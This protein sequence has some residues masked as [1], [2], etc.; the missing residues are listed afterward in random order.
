[1]VLQ[2]Y[3]Y[4]DGDYPKASLCS[5]EA[6]SAIRPGARGPVGV[7]TDT[8]CPT[9]LHTFA[10]EVE[11]F[12]ARTLSRRPVGVASE[13]D[14]IDVHGLERR[15]EAEVAAAVAAAV[16]WQALKF[17]AGLGWITGPPQ[18]GGRGLPAE[19][20]RLYA[21]RESAFH[22][23]DVTPLNVGTKMLSAAILGH[24]SER[25][26]QE[27]TPALHRGDLIGCQLFSE[28]D[29]GS[30]L[31]AVRASATRHEGTWR[32][33]GEKVWTS[34]AQ[35][36]DLG[37]CIARTAPAE[38]PHAGLTMFLVDMHAPGVDV[39]PLRQMNGH[40]SFN[41]VLLDDVHV[42]DG[43]RLG[44]VGE[45]WAVVRTT[46]MSERAGVGKGAMDLAANAL[47]R[48]LELAPHAGLGGDALVRQGLAD[49][50]GRVRIAD[51]V[52]QQSLA[53][54]GP[55]GSINKLFRSR[56]LQRASTLAGT[57]LGPRLAAGT[58]GDAMWT[59]LVLCVPGVRLGG[60]TDEIQLNVL[61]ERVLGLPREQRVNNEEASER[62]R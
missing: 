61:A 4:E 1:V 32:V 29:A 8:T 5:I 30:D 6:P 52:S 53:A 28:P 33:S 51:F 26:R 7:V 58:G 14:V 50:Y 11:Q 57:M 48:L 18:Y 12:L 23:P 49:L 17:D 24:G 55:A 37:L 56:N 43:A 40:A 16:A 34:K 39:R 31:S 19:F 21:E 47:G 15:P 45:G 62:S 54:P 38:D 9:D 44:E 22:A 35:F 13:P 10:L 20:E 36:S 59:D 2:I 27:V 41:Q 3:D 25:L 46:L 60:G 42:P